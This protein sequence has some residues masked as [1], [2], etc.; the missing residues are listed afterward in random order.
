MHVTRTEKS[1]RRFWGNP[2]QKPGVKKIFLEHIVR[3]IQ[4]PI[5]PLPDHFGI[6]VK[7]TFRNIFVY[8]WFLGC[9]A[10]DSGFGF[11]SA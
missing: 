4:T 7:M 2:T 5:S 1:K 9:V 6:G 11:F 10:P 3:P 8:P